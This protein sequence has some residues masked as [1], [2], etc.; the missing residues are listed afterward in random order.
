[1]NSKILVR[2]VIV[3]MCCLCGMPQVTYGQQHWNLPLLS[4]WDDDSI[5]SAWTGSYSECWGYV[6][7]NDREYAFLG[8]T[9]GTYI[10]DISNPAVPVLI[11]YF[12]TKDTSAL[13]VNKDYATYMH[14][15]YAVSDQGDNS[16]QIFDLQYLPDSVVKVY[17]TN[18]ISKRCHT[19][20]VENDRLYMASNTRPDGSFGPM[21]IFS[22]AD[23]LNPILLGTLSHPGF[24][25][26]HEVF[27][28]ND[29]AYC[30]NGING[31]WIYNMKFPASPALIS[32]VDVYAES[33]YNHSAWLTADSKTMVFTDETHGRG[34][35]VFDMTD[36]HDPQLKSMIRSNMLQVP[37]SLTNN[38]SVAHNPFIKGNFLFL[39]YYHDGVRVYDIS[40]PSNPKL[41]GW[42]D[43]H[44]QNTSYYSYNGC[45][46]VYP[47]LP[48][49]N[50]IA[51][52]ITNGLFILDGTG[53]K[54]SVPDELLPTNVV[55]GQNPVYN[56]VLLM[57]QT[58]KN[59]SINI[60]IFDMTG[61]L[62]YKK[63]ATLVS[64]NTELKLPV[65]ALSTGM[66]FIRL[67]G[68]GINLNE[69]FVK[70]LH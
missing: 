68:E 17:D 20:F 48:S 67:E 55:L 60:E 47:F 49:G 43:T 53:L 54:N 69:K 14:Y 61:K 22:L 41:I 33:G 23:P 37:D 46:G 40:N 31:L 35:K 51:S 59:T 1:M 8:S 4:N 3:L 26:V 36:I 27:V 29:T 28:K 52:D 58:N 56:E 21:D 50:I 45:W 34:V 57:Y 42:H 62:V 70:A 39:A 65:N 16:L 7:P 19:I 30:A 9:K 24:F 2:S 66:Y 63:D 38:G 6:A 10:F 64:G 12:T 32:I 15:L 18:A 11:N 25:S 5:P 13:V 44:P